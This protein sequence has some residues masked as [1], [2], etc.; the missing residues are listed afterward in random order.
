MN[1]SE[2]IGCYG[3]NMNLYIA[4]SLWLD[5]SLG[6]TDF[7]CYYFYKLR[8]S[9]SSYYEL[10]TNILL[11]MILS[12]K[13]DTLGWIARRAEMDTLVNVYVDLLVYTRIAGTS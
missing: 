8:I 4:R 11:N 10:I 5:I 9:L 6:I 2:L 12:V 7:P 1:H 13:L 3:L